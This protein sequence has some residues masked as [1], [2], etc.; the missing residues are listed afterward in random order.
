MHGMACGMW[1]VHVHVHVH[2]CMLACG[3]WHVH[4][5]DAHGNGG[6]HL[7]LPAA[8]TL[9]LYSLWQEGGAHLHM[10]GM[11]MCMCMCMM[12]MACIW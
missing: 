9:R 1:H 6:E 5:H 11:C 12:H 10:H 3:M 2:V 7:K 8:A 4:V